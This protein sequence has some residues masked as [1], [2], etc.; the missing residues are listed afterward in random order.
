LYPWPQQQEA[1]L[2]FDCQYCNQA[3]RRADDCEVHVL[4][5][6]REMYEV[7]ITAANPRQI[8]SSNP[9]QKSWMNSQMTMDLACEEARRQIPPVPGPFSYDIAP[10]HTERRELGLF[11][12]IQGENNSC[13]LDASLMAMFYVND[14]FDS[15]LSSDGATAPSMGEDVLYCKTFLTRHIINSVRQR[16]FVENSFVVE[17]RRMIEPLFHGGVDFSSSCERHEACDFIRFV[18]ET[19]GMHDKES[20]SFGIEGADSSMSEVMVQLLAPPNAERLTQSADQLLRYFQESQG[21]RFRDMGKSLILQLPRNGSKHR[22]V[23]AFLPDPVLWVDQHSSLRSGGKRETKD[24]VRTK[25]CF[26][27]RAVIVIGTGHFVTY[28]R[29]RDVDRGRIRWLY[30]DSMSDRQ[31]GQNVPLVEDVTKELGVLELP[32]ASSLF[33]DQASGSSVTGASMPPH[34]QRVT[35]DG[36]M[37]FYTVVSDCPSQSQMASSKGNSVRKK[38][39]T[40][41]EGSKQSNLAPL[42]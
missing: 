37:L 19:I 4:T 39:P 35:R 21:L 6:H 18:I 41:N 12:G 40:I 13:Y 28:M 7:G 22:P 14:T 26:E 15:L 9:E 20:V 16:G 38:A 30:A 1:K 5:Q 34:L 31:F 17:W 23:G 33:L 11:K 3:F 25:L 10:V 32:N 24:E 2:P 36:S 42:R 8:E 29:V 27:L